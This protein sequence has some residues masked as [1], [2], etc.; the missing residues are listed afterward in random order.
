M[1]PMFLCRGACASLGDGSKE[2]MWY[3]NGAWRIGSYNWLATKDLGAASPA[4]PRAT[5]CCQK[6]AAQPSASIFWDNL[7]LHPIISQLKEVDFT[8]ISDRGAQFINVSYT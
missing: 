3:H 2:C 8:I 1:L 4:E 6:L 7:P 5:Q